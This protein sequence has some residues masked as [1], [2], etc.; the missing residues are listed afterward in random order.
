MV[1]GP[2]IPSFSSHKLILT[3]LKATLG[4]RIFLPAPVSRKIGW[5]LYMGND[6]PE[7]VL[8]EIQGW[9]LTLVMHP[10]TNRLSARGEQAYLDASAQSKKSNTQVLCRN[11]LVTEHGD[12]WNRSP[13]SRALTTFSIQAV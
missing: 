3:T 7:A 10:D 4:A 6:F 2:P 13:I 11:D 1:K 9:N 8:S 12:V 5:H